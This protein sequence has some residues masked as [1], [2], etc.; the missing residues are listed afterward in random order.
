MKT[1]KDEVTKAVKAKPKRKGNVNGGFNKETQVPSVLC[2]FLGF[3]EETCMTRPK[4]VS[5]FHNKLSELK[6]K[7]GQNATLD[8]PTIKALGLGKEY[9]GKEIKFTQFQSL[10]AS[11]YPK[12]ETKE[13]T[14]EV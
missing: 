4:V 6:L 3:P 10:I 7:N 12:K 13:A 5:A 14:I 2:K 9:E 1:H 11:F 8:K